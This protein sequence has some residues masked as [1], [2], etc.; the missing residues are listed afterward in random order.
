MVKI[1]KSAE[2]NILTLNKVNWTT[3]L[4]GFINRNEKVPPNVSSRYN[5]DDIKKTLR[6][7]CNNKCMYCE[8]TIAH[9][10]YEHIEHIKPK[11]KTKFPEL[12]YEWMNLGLSC[13]I[14]NMN[15]GDEYDL[16]LPFINPYLENP[17]DFIFALGH[18]I[19]NKPAN[20]KGELTKR[21]LKLNR[22][23]L[24]ERRQERLESI[25]RL[26]ERY[27]AETNPTLK[28]AIR[29]EIEF[30]VGYEK[31]YSLCAKSIYDAM[32]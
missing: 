19:Y 5:Q 1:N 26:I 12:T 14:C 11:A 13:Q 31:P 8:S 7:E 29:S 20:T 27:H 21:Q 6:D 25:I 9:V 22:P 10:S 15:K 23:E 2:P 24:L 18:F 17:S 28:N 32:M 30:E 16:N 4:L 3:D